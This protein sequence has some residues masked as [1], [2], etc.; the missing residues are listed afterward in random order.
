MSEIILSGLHI[1]PVKSTAGISLDTAALTPQGLQGDR[2][3]MVVSANGQF[4]TQRRFPRMALVQVAIENVGSREQ[5]ML[6]APGMSTLQVQQPGA[7]DVSMTVEVW[8]D[9]TTALSCGT[10]A[11]DWFS[12]FLGVPCQLVYMPE[13][14]QRPVDHGKFGSEKIVSFAD[15]YPYLLLSEASLAGLNQKLV[16]RQAGAVPMNRFRPNLVVS[17]DIAPHAEDEWKRIRIGESVF[18][19]AKPCARC[20]IPN[21]DQSLGDRTKEPTATL[22][23]YRSWDRAIWFGQ[24]LIQESTAKQEKWLRVGDTVDILE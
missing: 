6:T 19:V 9:R 15:A 4:M 2:R 1:Y 10:D 12:Q 8:G 20:S 11:D 3:Y 21:V 7:E 23:T 16:D 22:S 17:G 24:N 14:S 18:D 13:T 5:L